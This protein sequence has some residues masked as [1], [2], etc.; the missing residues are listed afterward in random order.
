MGEKRR[1]YDLSFRRAAEARVV[2]WQLSLV[3]GPVFTFLELNLD[4]NSR[5]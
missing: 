1:K 5:V 3:C 2:A 4:V